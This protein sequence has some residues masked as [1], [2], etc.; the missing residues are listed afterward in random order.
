M[1]GPCGE[2]EVSSSDLLLSI[3]WGRR[4]E[5]VGVPSCFMRVHMHASPCVPVLSAPIASF[6]SASK[7]SPPPLSPFL[8]ILWVWVRVAVVTSSPDAQGLTTT[9]LAFL[10]TSH[11]VNC[12]PCGSAYNFSFRG[13]GWRSGSFCDRGKKQVRGG[14]P[15]AVS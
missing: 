4:A 3:W 14:N 5:G 7:P 15:L 13:P 6:T 11:V 9:H 12:G 8:L 1:R 2:S 10:L